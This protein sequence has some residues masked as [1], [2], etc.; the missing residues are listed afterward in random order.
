LG[1]II[2]Q[3]PTPQ[4]KVLS[5]SL[6]LILYFLSQLKILRGLILFKSI[7]TDKLLGTT[8]LMLSA[9]PPPVILAQPFNKFLLTR[10]KISFT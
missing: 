7:S 5:I 1:F 6:S 4:L 2:K 8:L 10:F 3:N 9:N